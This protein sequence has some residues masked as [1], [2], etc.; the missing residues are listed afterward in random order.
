MNR[1]GNNES[2][3]SNSGCTGPDPAAGGKTSLWTTEVGLK[4]TPV[5]HREGKS[6][7]RFRSF[8]FQSLLPGYTLEIFPLLEFAAILR[9]F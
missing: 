4:F 2:G 3:I 1:A 9:V 8:F 6:E 5:V 7:G